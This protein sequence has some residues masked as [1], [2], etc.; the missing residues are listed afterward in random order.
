MPAI[1]AEIN[2]LARLKFIGFF[3]FE[4]PALDPVPS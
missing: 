3:I 1:G 4:K 2:L